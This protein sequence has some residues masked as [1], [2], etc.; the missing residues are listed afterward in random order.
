MFYRLIEMILTGQD[1]GIQN[2]NNLAEVHTAFR[3]RLMHTG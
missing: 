2:L 1:F 3:I